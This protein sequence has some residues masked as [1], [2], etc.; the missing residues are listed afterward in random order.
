MSLRS[1]FLLLAH[2]TNPASPARVP[3]A[4][5]CSG[6]LL[7]ALQGHRAGMATLYAVPMA[8]QEEWGMKG[9]REE[10]QCPIIGL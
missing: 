6:T 7:V 10:C 2:S 8:V 4:T 3:S 5:R 1:P 9:C